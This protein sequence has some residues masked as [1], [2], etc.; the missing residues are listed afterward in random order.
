MKLPKLLLLG[1]LTITLSACDNEKSATDELME[2]AERCWEFVDTG[3][4]PSRGLFW[5]R[6]KA[7][8]TYDD[9]GSGLRVT[10]SD[11][12]SNDLFC[13]I[14]EHETAWSDEDHS[15]VFDAIV[16]MAPEWISS[17]NGSRTEDVETVETSEEGFR[18]SLS[19]TS[20]AGLGVSV[21]I[22]VGQNVSDE[23]LIAM[24]KKTTD[25]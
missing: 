17:W 21:S 15:A 1:V 3:D 10:F 24:L 9:K 4:F 2:M 20:N 23:I 25:Q 22:S 13:V 7:N 16:A 8:S 11:T 6:N 14:T 18:K 19:F 12:G 5:V